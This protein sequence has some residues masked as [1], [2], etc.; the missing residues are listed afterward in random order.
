MAYDELLADRVRQQLK[1]K[2]ASFEE[3]KMFGGLCFLV[4]EKMCVGVVK[5]DLMTRVDPDIY[6]QL[7]EENGARKMDFTQRPMKG[8]IFVEPEGVDLDDDLDNWVQ[9]CLDF[10]PK[11]KS[12]KKKK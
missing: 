12:S 7:L 4:D 10:N 6:E 8:F 5:N 3:R 9:Y 11:A 2:K 1:D